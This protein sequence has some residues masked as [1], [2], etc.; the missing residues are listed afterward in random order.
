MITRLFSIVPALL[1]PCFLFAQFADDFSDGDLT[2][3]PVWSGNDA[4]FT[5]VNDGGDPKLR[6]NSPGAGTYYLSTP[7]TL[8]QNAQ[9]EFFV[10]LRFSTSGSNYVDVYLIAPQADLGVRPDGYFV[11]IGDT[12]DHVVLYRRQSNTNTALISSNAGIVNSSSAN[13][14]RIK[15]TRDPSD[16]WT[17]YFDDGA[18]G[19]YTAA[20]SATDATFTN[21]THFG[22][23]IV[24]STA[25]GP[26]NNH[27]FDDFSAGPIPVDTQPPGITGITV[28]DGN[29]VD[30]LFDEPL[31]PSTATDVSNYVGDN[32]LGQPATATLVGPSTVRLTFTDPFSNGI[33]YAITVNNV[34][35]L[36]G[37]AIVNGTGSFLFFTP[38]TPQ[39]RDV[40][41]NE[42]MADPDPPVGLPN[43]EYIELFNATTDKFFDLTGWK[44]SSTSTPITLPAHVLAPGEH[45]LLVPS[46]NAPLFGGVENILV[47][48]IPALTNS[49]TTIT[50]SAPDDSIIDQ[51]TYA[52][53]WYGDPGKDDGGWSLEQINPFTPC[54]GIQNWSASNDE[55]GGTP[56]EQNS[57]LDPSPDTDPPALSN[58]Y[59]S[60]T[61]QIELLFSEPMNNTSLEAGSF[62][63]TPDLGIV[64]ITVLDDQ[65]VRID[66]A[67][68]PVQGTFYTITVNDV[69]DCVGNTIGANNSFTF[70]IPEQIATGDIVINEV[71]YDPPTGS[72]EWIEIYNRS[73]KVLDLQNMIAGHEPEDLSDHETISPAPW[74]LMPGNYAVLTSNISNVTNAYPQSRTERFLQ[75][76]L[77]SLSND[78]TTISILDSALNII[79][80]FD[81]DPDMHFELISSP[82]GYS[83]E[84]IDPERPTNDATNWQT[85][86]DV[87]GRATPGYQ[88]SQYA[89][90]A[91][92]TGELSIDPVV[93][94]PD[95]DG[96]Q[97]VLTITY[98]FDQ[99]G[100]VGTIMIFDVAGREVRRLMDSQLLGTSGAISWDGI[101]ENGSKGRIGPY[102][103]MMEAFDL[104]GNVER[105]KQTV[106]LAHFLD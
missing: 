14:F 75:M 74:I 53:A 20:G 103:I 15:V 17:L 38:D 89:P 34:Q 46:G 82:K 66:L 2:S 26:V 25:A 19:T 30:V 49:G 72:S 4:L 40:V 29:T 24:Q 101:L 105:F 94:S 21:S 73:N 54:S 78:G 28:I 59:I 88:N 10:D 22:I 1:L 47:T 76:T 44:I 84:R 63:I 91:I 58:A 55:D 43:A 16:N 68:S 35:D 106:T 96:F 80:R 87:A 13:P 48:N 36:A 31:D 65:R 92:A 86:A 45:V 27:F 3:D 100:F 8:A 56:G 42:L 5:V 9:W 93:F 39:F 62:S 6:S 69:S 102:I 70:A 51:V 79:D 83:L 77:P 90:T 52:M 23:V 85:A 97:D 11:R 98:Q 18:T 104:D 99:A 50:L 95:N 61:Q 7:S 41:I 12:E 67:S 71:M 60:S 81:Y 32:S 37:N 57:V 33:A 64:Q